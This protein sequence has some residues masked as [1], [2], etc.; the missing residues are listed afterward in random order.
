MKISIF[1]TSIFAYSCSLL[2]EL[3]KTL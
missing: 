2:R 3:F 1:L